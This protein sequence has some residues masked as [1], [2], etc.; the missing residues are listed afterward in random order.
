MNDNT[1]YLDNSATTA[2]SDGVKAR[3]REV[4]E[5]YGNPIRRRY[6]RH[7][8]SSALLRQPVLC[9]CGGT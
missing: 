6:R 2:L 3:M 5:I 7:D 4:M 9:P 8:R 1:V